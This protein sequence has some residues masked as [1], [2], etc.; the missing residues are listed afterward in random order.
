[1]NVVIFSGNISTEIEL[2]HTQTGIPVTSFN[3][4]VRRPGT[5]EKITDFFKIVAWRS[6]AEFI[7]GHFAKGDG[8]ELKCSAITRKY[9]DKN[10]NQQEV[11][12]FVVDEAD[13]GKAKKSNSQRNEAAYEQNNEV[14]NTQSSTTDGFAEYESDDLPF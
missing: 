8:I 12:E 1:M 7:S 13:F 2:K 9:K 6:K 4:A 14:A 3:L 5:K 10:G 11:T